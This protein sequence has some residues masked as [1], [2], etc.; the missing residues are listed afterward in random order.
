MKLTRLWRSLRLG[1]ASLGLA[2]CANDSTTGP[3]KLP[4]EA[5]PALL[6]N[7]LEMKALSRK[8]PLANDITVSATIGSAGGT[9]SIPEVGFTLMVPKGAVSSKTDFSVTALKGSIVAYEMTPHGVVFAKP[10][11]ARQQLKK[12]SQWN[13]LPLPHLKAAYY[14]DKSLLD[15]SK[16]TGL[17]SEVIDGLSNLLKGEFSW[18]INHFSGYMVCW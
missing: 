8:T 2:G 12:Y 5:S 10:L 18:Q 9:I 11:A 3:A 1:L 6:G 17:V 4:T 15:Q 13:G 14:T 7:L 16:L